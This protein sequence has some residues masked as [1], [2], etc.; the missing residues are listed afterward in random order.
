MSSDSSPVSDDEI[1]AGIREAFRKI[2]RAPIQHEPFP[3]IVVDEVFPPA[4]YRRL[5]EAVPHDAFRP[6][7]YPG[8]GDKAQESRG[9]IVESLARV[10]VFDRLAALLGGGEFERMMLAKFSSDVPG[11]PS[12]CDA[13]PHDK[14]K[15]YEDEAV[16]VAASFDLYKDLPGYAI[17]PHR[18]VFGKI[19]TF[20]FFMVPDHSLAEHGGTYFFRPKDPSK[21]LVPR[22]DHPNWYHWEDFTIDKTMRAIPNT[23]WAFVPNDRSYHG[24]RFE[25]PADHPLRERTVVRGFIRIGK[26]SGSYASVR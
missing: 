17:S 23:F 6:A 9:M 10:P 13:I 7:T 4:V 22:T 3:H 19:V 5:I 25:V 12:K 18:D 1:N 11:D 20:Q 16:G 24:V 2:E 26:T 15:V 21:A 14:R 8:S